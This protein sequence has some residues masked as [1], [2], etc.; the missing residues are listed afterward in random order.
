MD[1]FVPCIL[2]K[3]FRRKK[4]LLKANDLSALFKTLFGLVD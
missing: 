2:N 4:K 1:T 3:V